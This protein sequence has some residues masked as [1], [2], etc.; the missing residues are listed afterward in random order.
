MYIL[1]NGNNNNAINLHVDENVIILNEQEHLLEDLKKRTDF[2]SFSKIVFPLKQ[3]SITPRTIKD[4]SGGNHSYP[5]S[6]DPF[7]MYTLTAETKYSQAEIS[8]K[9]NI[10]CT[11]QFIFYPNTQNFKDAVL[12]LSKPADVNIPF[13][14]TTSKDNQKI[15]YTTDIKLQ[16]SIKNYIL[17]KCN[18][19]VIS[20]QIINGWPT[21]TIEFTYKDL[22][23]VFVDCNFTAYVKSSC[24]YVSHRKLNVIN[25]KARFKY[26]AIGV[27]S[28]EKSQIQVGIGKYTNVTNLLE[29]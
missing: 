9:E 28:N 12:S 26:I 15:E 11:V 10:D 1:F 20:T 18:L 5:Y 2:R 14:V 24:G 4:S 13:V 19:E 21:T 27:E 6:L 17:P 25:G 22:N 29:V 16:E 7:D 8:K 3:T 23:G